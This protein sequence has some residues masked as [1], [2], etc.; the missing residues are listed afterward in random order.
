MNQG[1]VPKWKGYSM[2][3]TERLIL[4][5]MEPEDREDIIT[6]IND[7]TVYKWTLKVPYPYTVKDFDG[8]M[9]LHKKWKKDGTNIQ[10]II[11]L[12]DTN[13]A[14][15]G[16]GIMNIDK[17]NEVAEVG[18]WISKHHR[19]NGLVPEA[20]EGVIQ[21]A[22]KDLNIFRLDAIIFSKNENSR[23]VLEKCGFIFEGIIRGKY[24]KDGKRIDGKMYSLLRT[25][26]HIS[27]T[28]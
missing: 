10:F 12:K 2:L 17:D 19:G 15:G 11:H 21:H 16:V 23:R 1:I 25:D 3:T 20:M 18:Y 6:H 14:I 9:E 22:F 27:G 24:L 13:E 26:P 28:K 4:R 7:R 8:Y 5:V